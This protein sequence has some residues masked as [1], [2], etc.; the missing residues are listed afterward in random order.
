MTGMQDASARFALDIQGLGQLR[1]QAKQDPNQALRGAAQQFE[2][3]FLSMMLKSMRGA[4]GEDSLFDTEQTQ[5]FTQLLDQQLAQKLANGRGMGL[6]DLMV[7]Q[8]TRAQGN[9]ASQTAPVANQAAAAA[10]ALPDQAPAA[11]PA[12]PLPKTTQQSAPAID[13]AR[14][15]V[16]KLWPHAAEAAKDLGV[17][18]HLLLGQAA[19]ESG[20]GRRE[21]RGDDGRNS[22]NLFGI[23][24]G[25]NWN[26]DVVT[27]TT[28]EYVGGVP[29]KKQ[30]VFRAYASYAEA[31]Q[32][33]ASLLRNNPR[34]QGALDRGGDA[35][36]FARAL[37]QG[38]Y[39]T[40]P[41]YAQK[42]VRVAGSVTMRQALMG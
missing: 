4:V 2:G 35:A 17:A 8:L 10:A 36:A 13:G 12:S 16:S 19:L 25:A 20:W 9:L 15:F 31:F 30:E 21:I 11:Q 38:G 28:T 7:R 23:K 26:G 14:D 5:M 39:A 1:L 33:Y 27:I 29:Q 18:P 40:D 37:Q 3:I 22:H 24:A 42:L 6:A 32:D 41:A 34:Y